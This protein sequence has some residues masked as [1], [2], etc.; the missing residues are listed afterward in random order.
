MGFDVLWF[1][2]QDASER[3]SE[4]KTTGLGK[5]FPFCVTPNEVRCS[6]ACSKRYRLFRVFEFAK[7][8]RMYVLSGALST[9]CHR[10]PTQ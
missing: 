3:F 4:V 6:A 2:E 1:D 8:P 7:V 10:E 5:F 9:V